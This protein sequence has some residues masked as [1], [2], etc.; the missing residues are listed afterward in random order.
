M[1]FYKQNPLNHFKDIQPVLER[2]GAEASLNVRNFHLELRLNGKAYTLCPQFLKLEKGARQYT[3]FFDRQVSR[4]IGWRPYFNKRWDLSD[5]KLKFKA[6]A[7]ANGLSTPEYSQDPD[8]GIR[9]VLVKKSVSSFS[10]EIKGPF[11]SSSDCGLDAGK[12]EFYERFVNGRTTKIYYFENR[13]VCLEFQS[14]ATVTGDGK[15][16]IKQL[17]ES[18]AGRREQR[19]PLKKITGYLSYAGKSLQDVVEFGVAQ[20]IDFKYGSPFGVPAD[21]ENVD[22]SSNAVP[23]LE[24]QLRIIGDC[25]WRGI[26]EEIRADTVFTVDAIR[27]AND[28]LWVTEMNANPFIHPF[29]YPAMLEALIKSD[30]VP[31]FTLPQRVP[32]PNSDAI[33]E[34]LQLA[35]TQFTGGAVQQA[36]ALWSKVL[37]AYPAHPTALFYSGLALAREGN[38]AEAKNALDILLRTA[39]AENLYF[40]SAKEL[41]ASVNGALFNLGRG[42]RAE[43]NRAGV[44]PTGAR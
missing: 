30:S 10:E 15:R 26:P 39:P 41:L 17:L 31:Q 38:L 21:L 3:P 27:D 7:V 36:K 1:A 42:D 2:T 19:P 8:A 13:P 44:L 23:E 18:R 16:T 40:A 6:Y 4:F 28:R 11:R 5:E 37:G 35:I 12:G 34:I 32:P 33:N 24:S 20:Q 25:L 14:A 22:L 29:V 43:A 9:D